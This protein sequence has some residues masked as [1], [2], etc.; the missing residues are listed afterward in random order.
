M[1]KIKKYSK[2]TGFKTL[3]SHHLRA[4]EP[5]TKKSPNSVG[6][7]SIY[8]LAYTVFRANRD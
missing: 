8:K 6:Y 4:L 2:N 5:F 1:A 3:A 7:Q